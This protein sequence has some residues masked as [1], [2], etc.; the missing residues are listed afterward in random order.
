M[1][2][3][4]GATGFLGSYLAK[5]LIAGGEKVRALKRSQSGFELLGDYAKQIEWVEGDL[6]DN[7]SI[8][9]ALN[10]VE[11]IYHCAGILTASQNQAMLVNT[12]GTANLF[13]SALYMQVKKVVHVSST[14]ALGLP[15]NNAIIDENY[16]ATTAKP[17]S[18]Y[19]ESKRFGELEA[20]RAQA[21]G[22]QVVVVNPAAI[23]GGGYW[24]HGPLTA[25][26]AVKK[27]LKFYPPG[28][29]GFI[30]VRDAAEAMIYL[31]ESE[32]DG[33]RFILTAGNLSLKQ[34]LFLI[35]D[36][37]QKPKPVYEVNRFTAGL[38]G[39]YEGLLAFLQ[40]REPGF[41]KEDMNIARIPFNYNNEKITRTTGLKFRTMEQMVADTAA[42]F[43]E[44]KNKGLDYGVF[45]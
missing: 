28:S 19:F 10:G 9:S 13:N 24:S 25:F 36:A 21:E 4:T 6:L 45:M 27:G 12:R 11:K 18:D 44:S 42:C 40:G 3:I 7:S 26:E 8:E 43:L 1:I 2:F 39:R 38:A 16:Y 22:L 41:T 20:W 5:N 31:M 29:N 33:E 14:M 34:Y 37:M 30:D 17:G 23:I 35:A 32:T 15:V